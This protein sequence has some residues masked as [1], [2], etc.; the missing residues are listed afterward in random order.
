M[1][2]VGGESLIDLILPKGAATIEQLSVHAG[3]SPYNCAL[4]L[5]K[6][7][8]KVGFL[9]PMSSDWLSE[10]LVGPLQAAGVEI[11]LKD[12][13]WEPTT[14]ALVKQRQGGADY[15]FYRHADRVLSLDTLLP[16]LPDKIEFF[17]IGGFCPLE[18]DDAAVWL[19]V[20][21]QARRRGAILSFDPNLRPLAIRDWR[22]YQS[23]LEAFFGIANLVKLSEEDVRALEPGTSVEAY[24]RKLL[25]EYASCRLVIVT[26]GEKGSLAYTARAEAHYSIH[27]VP[28][29][30]EE[31]AKNLTE[32]RDT[33]GAG[34]CF[35]GGLAT[36]LQERGAMKP[37]RL[38]ALD[39]T[40]LHDILRFGAVVAGLNC[41]QKGC[42]PP[43]RAAVDEVLAGL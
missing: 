24:A 22:S 33:V 18:A 1:F 21:E 10:V 12:R 35:L 8:Q 25:R 7:G 31:D 26:L 11:L 30:P 5:A 38:G 40:E 16:A 13:V 14:L 3:G 6:L 32:T 27:N 43:S 23:R 37:D 42:K 39:A 2:V 36:I 4:A 19:A 29:R 34:D 9:S 28:L 17:Q 15:R 20:A 41:A